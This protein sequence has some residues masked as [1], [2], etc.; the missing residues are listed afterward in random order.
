MKKLLTLT[1]TFLIAV[2]TTL[3][4]DHNGFS[5]QTENHVHVTVSSSALKYSTEYKDNERI[6]TYY[7]S[8]YASISTPS[9]QGVSADYPDR[10]S[11]D[12]FAQVPGKS[13]HHKNITREGEFFDNVSRDKMWKEKGYD[14]PVFN[15]KSTAT[16]T[17]KF[18]IEEGPIDEL[19]D[20]TVEADELTFD[21]PDVAQ[22]YYK[23]RVSGHN[24][25]AIAHYPPG[26]SR[27]HHSS[28]PYPEGGRSTQ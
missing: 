23:W 1:A 13:P 7:A 2:C 26:E 15:A 16:T 21:D 24:H 14:E 5:H 9:Q 8:A 20:S 25:E 19:E 11:Y 22:K 12:L 3:M 28:T 6:T 17:M 18:V 10:H 27:W 4:I